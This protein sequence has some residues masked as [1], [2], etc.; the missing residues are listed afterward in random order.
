MEFL[1]FKD[2]GSTGSIEGSYNQD[3]LKRKTIVRNEVTNK[4]TVFSSKKEFEKWYNRQKNKHYHEVILEY[5]QQR[6]K[7]DIDIKSTQISQSVNI[8]HVIE[9]ILDSIIKIVLLYTE[10]SLQYTD[11]IVTDSSGH[12][13]DIYKYSYHIILFTYAVKSTEDSKYI[14]EGV[15]NLVPEEYKQYIDNGVNKSIQNFRLLH[16]SKKGSNR[17]KK[18]TDQFGTN[19]NVTL[20]DTM[21][22]PFDGIKLLPI[23]VPSTDKVNKIEEKEIEDIVVQNIIK[24]ISKFNILDGHTFR[25]CN[26][27]SINFDRMYPTHCIICNEIHHKDNSLIVQYDDMTGNIYEYCRQGKKNRYVCNLLG[28]P[29]KPIDLK[30]KIKIV[31]NF[32]KIEDSNKT[33]YSENKMRDYELVD[34]LVVHAQMK[35]GKTKQLHKYIQDHFT[36][37]STICFVTFRQTFSHHIYRQFDTFE[38]YSNIKSNLIDHKRYKRLIIQVESLY[39]IKLIESIDLLI[40]DEVESIIQQ[41]SSGL[42]KHFNA[43]FA[44]FLWLLQTAKRVVC[45]DAN[46]SNRT[47]NILTRFRSKPIHYHYNT[48]QTASD[49]TY[50]VTV[51]LN[52]WLE[53]LFNCV[54][55]NKRVVIPTN[56]ITDAK[57]CEGILLKEFPDLKIKIYS[58]ENSISE[59]QL[60]FNNVHKYWSEL[61]ILI[62][63]P[64]CTAGI[65]YELEHFDVLFGIFYNTSCNIEICRQMIGRVR[66]IKDKK[67]YL[68]LHEIEL[69]HY[70]E[71]LYELNM[72]IYNKR[73]NM[74]NYTNDKNLSWKY[75][76]DGSVK[77]YETDYYYVWLENTIIDNLSKNNFITRFCNQIKQN[78]SKIVKLRESYN[79]LYMADYKELKKEINSKRDAEIAES[80]EITQEEAEKI[81]EKIRIQE[82][83][84]LEE[85]RSYEKYKLRKFYK[86]EGQISPSFVEHYNQRQIQTIYKNLC[87]IL[88][89][90]TI[91]QSIE[92]MNKREQSRYNMIINHDANYKNKLE[93]TDLNND[94]HIYTSLSHIIV[95]HIITTIGNEYLSLDQYHKLIDTKIGPY[96]DNNSMYISIEFKMNIV[97][98][99]KKVVINRLLKLMY[100]LR[101]YKRNNKVKLKMADGIKRLFKIVTYECNSTNTITIVTS[102]E[103]F[104]SIINSI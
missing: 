49:D 92:L 9:T 23:Q 75:D 82:D 26:G 96:I 1:K 64:T 14:T 27:N 48:W 98:I 97:A 57:T 8:Q 99:D 22:V 24:C 30:T 80:P 42:H 86:Y 38:L 36:D 13:D 29:S 79:D 7:F 46:I 81:L 56:S 44:I 28:K 43:S 102:N 16:S 17:V 53:Q 21:I 100:G 101:M 88:Q 5:Q 71:S 39:R 89:C 69:P 19:T 11:F 52:T 55:N 78:G 94:C 54:K 2:D 72:Y 62:Y 58:S 67:Y 33:V 3:E 63:T 47:Y 31:N 66:Q 85:K 103:L 41:L 12:D 87:D 93:Y 37:D 10:I 83:T 35:L 20:L 77:F 15:I 45:M 51:N 104:L 74:C 95:C 70:P 73:M 90:P 18:I 6:L 68:L 32:D 61:D 84:T 50:Y 60:H 65:S 4:F 59:K 91:E 76:Y 40:L 25:N 34:T